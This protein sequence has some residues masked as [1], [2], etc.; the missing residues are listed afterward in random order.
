MTT[1]MNQLESERVVPDA[2]IWGMRVNFRP[3]FL[4]RKGRLEIGLSRTALWAGD[5]RPK[6]LS[7]FTDLLLGKDNFEADDP[8]K[9]TEPG[10]QL[11]IDMRYGR[12]FIGTS[13]PYLHSSDRRR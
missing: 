13:S 12:P 6:S 10:N 5:G 1:F 3:T 8:G 9:A 7:V 11:G 4:S 2:L